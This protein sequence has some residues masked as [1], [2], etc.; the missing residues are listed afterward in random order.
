MIRQHDAVYFLG[1]GNA[2]FKGPYLEDL[3]RAVQSRIGSELGRRL[4]QEDEQRAEERRQAEVRRA[5]G[6]RQRAEAERR[7]VEIRAETERRQSE[8][9]ADA[10]RREAERRLEIERIETQRRAEALKQDELRRQAVAEASKTRDLLRDRMLDCIRRELSD[11]VRSGEGAE[12][13]ASAS[14]TICA[15]DVDNALKAAVDVSRAEQGGTM[16][17]AEADALRTAARGLVK[18]MV[19]AAAVKAKAARASTGSTF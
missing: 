2:F 12:T 18:E 14:M 1:S 13:L 10:E 19:V 7:A 17:Y 15:T 6:E 16:G 9:R 5:E 3:T 11:L 4:A 8:A